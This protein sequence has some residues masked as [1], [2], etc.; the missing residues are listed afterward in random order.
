MDKKLLWWIFAVTRGGIVRAKI[1]RLLRERPMNANQIAQ[2][3]EM[4]YT[5]IRY[6]L[7]TL[8]KNGIVVPSKDTYIVMYF[9]SEAM[10][11]SY[12][13]FLEIYEKIK[14]E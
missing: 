7:D 14:E 11:E 9:L 6:H 8:L 12:E 5:T 3:L 13:D 1:V 2:E 4:D 10:E